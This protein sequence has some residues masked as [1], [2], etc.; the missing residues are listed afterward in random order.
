MVDGGNSLVV[1]ARPI[2]HRDMDQKT[3]GIAKGLTFGSLLEFKVWIKDF[4]IKHHRPYTVGHSDL[5]KRYTVKCEEDRCPWIVRVRPLKGGS[6]W[7]ITSCVSTHMCRGKKID[8]KD[9]KKDHPQ[10]TSDFIAF[11]L[12]NEISSLPTMSIKDVQALVKSR[13]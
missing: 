7:H 8:G 2:S 10:L 9:V 6:A 12:S 5:K 13:F 1:G 11:K 3:N 4:S